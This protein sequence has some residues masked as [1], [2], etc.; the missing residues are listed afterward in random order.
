MR[1]NI[2]L[3]LTVVSLFFTQSLFAEIPAPKADTRMVFDFAI[4]PSSY[5]ETG[6]HDGIGVNYSIMLGALKGR[7]TNGVEFYHQFTDR[8]DQTLH[9]TNNTISLLWDNYFYLFPYLEFKWGFGGSLVHENL[10][11]GSDS[12]KNI[13]LGPSFL[14]GFYLDLPLDFLA[15]EAYNKIDFLLS[16]G[17]G[18]ALSKLAQNYQAGIK[19]HFKPGEGHSSFYLSCLGEFKSYTENIS[20]YGTLFGNFEMGYTLHYRTYNSEKG[21][22]VIASEALTLVELTGRKLPALSVPKVGDLVKDRTPLLKLI[23]AKAGDEIFFMYILFDKKDNS[24]ASGALNTVNKLAE[25][26]KVH[27]SLRVSIVAYADPLG[28]PVGEYDQIRKRAG[29]LRR[30]LIDAGVAADQLSI[31]SQGIMVYDTDN[32][33]ETKVILK[34]LESSE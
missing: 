19:L 33:K 2:F 5:S 22:R 17:T 27:T 23:K 10:T 31:S 12:Y 9:M 8:T 15:L 16:V 24:L 30:Y 29:K 11:S 3:F 34:V 28:D 21:K 26:L 6:F 18:F 14:M 13:V 32:E 7:T 4:A 20:P 25:I 1:I